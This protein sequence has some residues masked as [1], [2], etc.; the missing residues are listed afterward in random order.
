MRRKDLETSAEKALEIIDNSE[1]GILIV[2][3]KTGGYSIPMSLAREDNLIYFHTAKSGELVD[4]L[5]DRAKGSIV[6]VS[7]AKV[8]NKYK[9]EEIRDIIK[10]GGSHSGKIFTTEYNSAIVKGE[11]IKL[12]NNEEKIQGLK[13][14]AKKYDE[15]MM[16]FFDHAIKASITKTNV[17]RF[18]IREISGKIKRVK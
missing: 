5:A 17:Y 18:E 12:Q 9:V 16:E 11:Y 3:T 7:Y 15:D 4:N 14:I 1:Y 10:S 13:I 8:P 6:F 2:D